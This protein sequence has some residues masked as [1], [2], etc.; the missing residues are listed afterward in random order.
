[1]LHEHNRMLIK[2]LFKKNSLVLFIFTG[3]IK[4]LNVLSVCQNQMGKC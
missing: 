3:I 2:S 1:M 4:A